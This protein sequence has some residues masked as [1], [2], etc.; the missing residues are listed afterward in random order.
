MLSLCEPD[1]TSLI[2]FLEADR[3]KTAAPTEHY[4]RRICFA[5]YYINGRKEFYRAF[6]DVSKVPAVVNENEKLPYSR[7][8][9][10]DVEGMVSVE[11]ACLNSPRVQREIER[12]KMPKGSEVVID[13]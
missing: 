8:A 13:A 2:P 11:K 6:V 3:L 4:P 12:Q 10:S 5:H 9:I 1:K 7:H